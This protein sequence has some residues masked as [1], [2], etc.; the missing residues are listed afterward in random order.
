MLPS[1]SIVKGV[2]MLMFST[3]SFFSKAKDLELGK[4]SRLSVT[5]YLLPHFT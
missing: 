2:K 4:I 1:I 3:F 5:K